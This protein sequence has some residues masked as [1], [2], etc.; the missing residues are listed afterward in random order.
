MNLNPRSEDD[1]SDKSLYDQESYH[2]FDHLDLTEIDFQVREIHPQQDQ[3]LQEEHRRPETS[4]NKDIWHHLTRFGIPALAG[5]MVIQLTKGKVEEPLPGAEPTGPQPEEIRKTSP[6]SI[7]T[8]IIPRTAPNLAFDDLSAV[9]RL[10]PDN[11]T[12]LTFDDGPDKQYTLRVLD[13]LD[14]HK[15]KATFFVTGASVH[16]H[17]EVLREIVKRGHEV[18]LHSMTHARLNGLSEDEI[19]WEI[20]ETRN[21]INTALGSDY[22]VQWIRA[23]Y[24][25][26]NNGKGAKGFSS[27]GSKVLRI[28]NEEGYAVVHWTA[29]TEDWRRSTSATAIEGMVAKGEKQIVLMHDAVDARLRMTQYGE[30]DLLSKHHSNPPVHPEVVGDKE[31][32]LRGLDAGLN[33]LESRGIK[34]K[35][36]SDIF[37]TK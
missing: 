33:R 9:R 19:R 12:A 24:G 17:P 36:L 10:I 1:R 2:R 4:P 37:V 15:A 18:G 6:S 34:A 22:Q 30:R 5:L 16:R 35:T 25:A 13:I 14:R 32:M 28:A 27:G 7:P 29:D 3:R 23:P 8:K 26:I 31:T 20:R 21:A 11:V